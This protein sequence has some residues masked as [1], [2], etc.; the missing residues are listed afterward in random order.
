MRNETS[1]PAMEYNQA[2]FSIKF[3]DDEAQNGRFIG[4][5]RT[6]IINNESKPVVGYGHP[7]F[8]LVYGPSESHD[9]QLFQPSDVTL[10]CHKAEQTRST[11]SARR[12]IYRQ[13]NK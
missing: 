4:D 7:E 6:N 13:I 10:A 12:F 2:H 9:K 11:Q 3:G 5:S 1:S 8:A